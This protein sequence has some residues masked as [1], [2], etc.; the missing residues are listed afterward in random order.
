LLVLVAVA[1]GAWF[2]T[3]GL[4]DPAN[5]DRMQLLFWLVGRDLEQ[6][7]YEVR[8]RLLHR[9][10]QEDWGNVDPKR[11]EQWL[12]EGRRQ[13]LDRNI[14][15]LVEPWFF[16]KM[17]QYY[18]LPRR[19]RSAYLDQ[20]LDRLTKLRGAR[21]AAGQKDASG[22]RV[23]KVLFDQVPEWRR[24]ADPQQRAEINEFLLALEARYLARGLLSPFKFERR[25]S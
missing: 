4:P 10:E 1:G 9:L 7:P 6:E 18:A 14:A 8:L 3:G 16:D 15:S 19:Q 20:V 12:T 2:V 24:R 13:Q 21:T 17:E 11:A 22:G 23:A 5:C 25:Q